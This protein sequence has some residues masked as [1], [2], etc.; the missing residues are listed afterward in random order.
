MAVGLIFTL[1]GQFSHSI[2]L[3]VNDELPQQVI[4]R[5]ELLAIYTMRQRHWPDGTPITVFMLD[6]SELLKQFC[7]KRL[8]IFPHQLRT[9]WDRLVYSGTGNAPSE[10]FSE[11]ELIRKIAN[12]RGAIGFI[13]RIEDYD[14]I[15]TISVR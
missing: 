10:V 5:Q 9:R 6:N 14:H 12:N 3:V 4:S 7:K 13:S 2:E 8:K 1:S 11:D 15:K